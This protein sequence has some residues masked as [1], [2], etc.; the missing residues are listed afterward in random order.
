MTATV[1]TFNPIRL[2]QGEM[3]ISL[4]VS[5]LGEQGYDALLLVQD[6]GFPPVRLHKTGNSIWAVILQTSNDFENDSLDDLLLPWDE[7]LD[8]LREAISNPDTTLII[9]GRF[10]RDLIAA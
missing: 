6:L 8:K 7:S 1:Q 4:N 9:A 10:K 3:R 2:E 5:A